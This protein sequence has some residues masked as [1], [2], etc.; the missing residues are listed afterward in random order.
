RE[1]LA[2]AVPDAFFLG[3]LDTE[4]L[5]DAYNAADLLL[6]PSWF[7]T[8]SCSLLEA[9][10]CGLPAVAFRAKGPR[11]IL[12]GGRGGLVADSP[13]DMGELAADLLTQPARLARL[14]TAARCRAEDYR[15][16]SI[17]DALI[18]D[19]GLASPGE[20]LAPENRLRP[21]SDEAIAEEPILGALLALM[22]S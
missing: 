15:A 22:D 19:L 18:R 6:L 3:W 4:R 8:F 7:D 11:D 1:R 13:A 10:A 9:L 21:T 16:T 2:A 5:A 12:A 20:G 17:L 14:R